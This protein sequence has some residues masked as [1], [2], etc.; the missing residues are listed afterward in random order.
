MHS[1]VSNKNSFNS[2][3]DLLN[4]IQEATERTFLGNLISVQSDCPGREKFGYG[5][6]LNATSESF[7]Y[8]FDMHSFYRKTIYDWVDAMNDSIF[9]DTAP[10]VGINYCGL[11]WES[12]FLITQYYLY[13]YYNCLLYT[14]PSPR[15]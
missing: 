10:F 4:S 9:V 3:L 1:N 8:N 6:D 11:S 7:I 15:D 13:L 12:A 5:G 14:S 2:S